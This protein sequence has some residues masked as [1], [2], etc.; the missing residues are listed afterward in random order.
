MTQD[1][2]FFAKAFLLGIIEGLTEFLPIS[3]TGHL[4]L[5]GDWINF[6]SGTDKVFEVVIQLG[7]ILAVTWIYREKIARLV[8]GVLRR[9]PTSLRF[10]GLVLV[11]FLPAAVIGAMFI[12]V[13]KQVLFNPGVVAAALIVGGFVILWAE[14]R[15]APQ[16]DG[17][18][19]E[20]MRWGQALAVGLAQCVAMI[21]GTSRSG[22]TI[23]GGMF[24]GLSR[25]TATE[26]SF[27][28][29][30]P[31][32]LGAAVYDGWRHHDALVA[33]DAIAIGIGFVAAFFSALLV[34]R[35]LIRF[36]ASHSF[37]VFAWYRIALGLVVAVWW[38][39]R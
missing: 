21:P 12:G 2:W 3:S 24:A 9:D 8:V 37:R 5:I 35:A 28:L 20:R 33:T 14:R 29:A 7:A 27:F 19:P 26:F 36:V 15:P 23:I 10:A 32:M 22:A 18:H 30:M 31:T 4:I 16:E 13:I 25:Q 1:V 38:A 11:A 34:V 6:D 17:P 39:L